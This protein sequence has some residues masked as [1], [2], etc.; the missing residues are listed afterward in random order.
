MQASLVEQIYEASFLPESWPR[1]LER[2]GERIDAP[3]GFFAVGRFEIERFMTTPNI[4]A[5]VSR[6]VR[7]RSSLRGNY[8]P[9]MFETAARSP[10]FVAEQEVLN[11]EEIHREPV[12][13]DY[14][15][16][17]GYCWGAVACVL[18][19]T[20]ENVLLSWRR[21]TEGGPLST[22]DLEQLDAL[23]PELARAVFV[24]SRLRLERLRAASETLAA[25]GLPAIVL[26]AGGKALVANHL[27]E[28]L[29][30]LVAWRAGDA[31][32]LK[33]AAADALLRKALAEID[34]GGATSALSFPV[35]DPVDPGAKMVAHVVPIRLG[36]RD[37]FSCGAAALVLTPVAARYAPP[38][39]L[40][41]SLFDLTPSEAL[42]ARSLAGG[43]TVDEIAADSGVSA[44]TV[45]T[46]VRG[47]LEKTG[48]HRQT[49]VVALLA[50]MPVTRW[51]NTVAY[52]QRCF[53]KATRSERKAR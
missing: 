8:L 15:L 41:Q 5:A 37:I 30:H 13:R 9:K 11:A 43:R 31:M 28:A 33:D 3:A 35:R 36:A 7:D 23:R 47:V 48:C 25:L 32:T 18:L 44:G 50:G 17:E 2:I 14:Y 24:A 22:A 19:P 51:A 39:E 38:V 21:R 42:V 45:R 27:A 12:F 40:L 4:S 10:R 1:V 49:D 26:D 46:H 34:A 6:M 20:G 29:D 16:P 52:L 53:A